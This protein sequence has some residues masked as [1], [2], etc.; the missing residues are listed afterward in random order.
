MSWTILSILLSLSVTN[1]SPKD[2]LTI[3]ITNDVIVLN[4]DSTMISVSLVISNETENDW[5]FYGLNFSDVA[6]AFDTQEGYCDGTSGA[7]TT[8]FIFNENDDQVFAEISVSAPADIDYK[9]ISLDMVQAK[10]EEGRKKYAHSKWVV[11]PRESRQIEKVYDLKSYELQKGVYR[12]FLVYHAGNNTINN[13]GG[14]KIITEDQ[15]EHNAQLFQG[16]IK[17]N[18]VKL[19]VK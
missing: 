19:V 15:E 2:T 18:T 11:K 4:E 12:L 16:C 1:D 8:G 10:I 5:L 14:L 6:H 9:P 7:G 3:Q 13:V 17:S